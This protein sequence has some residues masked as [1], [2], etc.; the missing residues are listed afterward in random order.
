MAITPHLIGPYERLILLKALS[1]PGHIPA[2]ALAALAGQATERHF[3][4]GATL[5]G[6]DCR[7]D[8]VHILVEGGVT[9]SPSGRP[10]CTVGP[11][12]AIG[13]L[14]VLAR[15]E[16]GVEARATAESVTLEV[17]ATTLFSVLD[18]H[19]EMTLSLVRELARRLLASAAAGLIWPSRPV[20]DI[21]PG[22][23]DLVDRIRLL[24]RTDLFARTRALSLG[25][26]ASQFDECQVEAG[27]MLWREGDP[28]SWLIVLLAG[29]VDA[30]SDGGLR[31]SW[32]PGTAP[33]TLDAI[34]GAPR[35]Y[36]AR[37]VTPVT[38]LRLSVDRLFDAVEDDFSMAEDL[39]AALATGL[40]QQHHE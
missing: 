33:G 5:I 37:A 12:E 3:A 17:D 21:S 14:E 38:A 1:P 30:S 9:V 34:A 35:W 26:I 39:L 18:D 32:G 7:C 28:A 2:P 23:I 24:Q 20:K 10:S 29:E 16:G 25:E 27:T 22:R 31:H 6:L 36:D 13:L 8:A 19:L 15:V 40:R 11:R 4:A